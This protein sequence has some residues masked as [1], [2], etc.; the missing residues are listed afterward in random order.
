MTT[1]VFLVMMELCRSG[2][3]IAT[4]LSIVR[5]RRTEIPEHAKVVRNILYIAQN[6]VVLLFGAPT[7][8]LFI[9]PSP[10]KTP[11]RETKTSLTATLMMK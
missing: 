3:V 5:G 1:Q 2:R 9:I 4:A 7:N 8:V 6:G 10:L 11:K